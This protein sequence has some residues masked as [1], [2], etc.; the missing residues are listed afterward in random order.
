MSGPQGSNAYQY[1]ISGRRTRLTYADGFYV[2][3]DY[4]VVGNVTAIRE[5]GAGSGV[6]VLA[7]YAYDALGRRSGVTFGNGTTQTLG[8]DAASRLT[9]LASDLGGTAQDQSVTFGYNPAGQIATTTRAND[10]YAWTQHYNIDRLYSVNGLNQLLSAGQL[11]IAHDARGNLT[12]SGTSTYAYNADNLLVSGPNGASLAY[13][14]LGRLAQSVGAG[15]T[16]R[17]A[18]DGVNLIAEYNASNPLLRRYVHGPGSDEPI[19]WYEGAS[20]TDRRFLMRDERGSIVSVA[21]A[22]GTTIAINSYDEYGI[23][24]SGN[25][26]QVPIYWPDLATGHWHVLLQSPPLLPHARPL[27]ADRPHRLCRRHEHVCLRRW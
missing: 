27:H 14:P 2:A 25:L 26:G 15:V 7:A 10:A 19:V 13:D 3:Y 20:T 9:S 8:F 22:S 16:T 23:P 6:G 12:T 24:A 1:D 11:G 18:Y 5:N 4:D 21:N 17:F